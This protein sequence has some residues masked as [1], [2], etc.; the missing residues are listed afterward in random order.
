M[1]ITT[2]IVEHQG[3]VTVASAW[4]VREVHVLWPYLTNAYPV[5]STNGGVFGIIKNFLFGAKTAVAA[6]TQPVLPT[7]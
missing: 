5:A 4:L 7:T 3:A 2:F 1:N 6:Q